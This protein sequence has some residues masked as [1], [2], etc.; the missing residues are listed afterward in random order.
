MA[1]ERAGAGKKPLQR[2]KE[3]R[4]A[5][6]N[7]LRKIYARLVRH[8][9]CNLGLHKWQMKGWGRCVRKRCGVYRS[10]GKMAGVQEEE[11]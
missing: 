4:D 5:L 8:P 3:I 7:F 2:L 10:F 1:A 6:A 9:L 11:R